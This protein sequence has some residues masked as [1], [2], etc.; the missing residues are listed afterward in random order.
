MPTFVEVVSY[1]T[2]G[3]LVVL[4]VLLVFVVLTKAKEIAETLDTLKSSKTKT[5]ELALKS[6]YIKGASRTLLQDQLEQR[7]FYQSTGLDAERPIREEIIEI[8]HCLKGR[9]RFEHF[10]RAKR[11]YEFNKEILSIQWGKIQKISLWIYG[12]SFAM[13][14]FSFI[15]SVVFILYTQS[16][17]ITPD[18]PAMIENLYISAALFVTSII[19]FLCW[20]PLASINK[21]RKLI[22]SYYTHYRPSVKTSS[23]ARTLR[24]DF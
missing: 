15:L 14:I 23:E 9:V 16:N 13:S 4:I 5:L 1:V 12:L 6:K 11:Q 21:T 18:Y 24:P 22:D 20:A 10:I 2:N 17:L 19:Y 3:N 7:Y 8:H